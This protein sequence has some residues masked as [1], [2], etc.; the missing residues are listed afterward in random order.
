MQLATGRPWC[1]ATK[2]RHLA[3]SSAATASNFRR[4]S[5]RKAEYRA[6][7]PGNPERGT[8]RSTQLR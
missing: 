6:S 4:G 1:Q 5:W 2:T 7:V 8:H 3:P